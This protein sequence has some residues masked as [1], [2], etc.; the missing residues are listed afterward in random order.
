MSDADTD[1]DPVP[2][3]GHIPDPD[4]PGGDGEPVI[5]RSGDSDEVT[6]LS[7]GAP[8]PEAWSA[9]APEVPGAP[10]RSELDDAYD[11]LGIRTPLEELTAF[12]GARLEALL[13]AGE[14]ERAELAREARDLG[15]EALRAVMTAPAGKDGQA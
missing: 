12:A 6:G 4:L 9:Q 2:P 14:P 8:T 13:R 7:F 3:T 11:C 5:Y 10:P 15:L 1:E